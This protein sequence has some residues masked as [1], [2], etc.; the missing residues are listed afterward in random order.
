MCNRNYISNRFYLDIFQ[1][2]Q[3]QHISEPIQRWRLLK[4]D[5]GVEVE[6][7]REAGQE[8]LLVLQG[9]QHSLL[10]LRELECLGE[11]R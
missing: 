1:I 8:A 3:N 5:A 7:E 4:V 2:Y 9:A 11:T 10:L 6:A